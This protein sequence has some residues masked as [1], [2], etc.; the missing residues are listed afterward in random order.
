MARSPP[1][2]CSGF[3]DGDIGG[4]LLPR[5][6]ASREDLARVAAVYDVSTGL[7]REHRVA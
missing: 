6:D 4:V 1:R 2:T 3:I 7:Q 5:P